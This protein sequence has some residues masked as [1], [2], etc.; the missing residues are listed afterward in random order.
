MIED[1]LP[2]PVLPII[3]AVL[4]SCPALVA[5]ERYM[6]PMR[7]GVKLA[8]NVYLP[9][10]EGP[11]PVILS[12]T[13]YGRFKIDE[14]TRNGYAVVTQDW[15]G[16]GGSEGEKLPFEAEGWGGLRDGYDTM[17]WIAA[18][19][20]CNGKVGTW[21][22]SA[23]GIAQNLMAGSYP[24][25]LVCQHI[26]AAAWD[27]Y[28]DM[29]FQGGVL[30]K[31]LV[32]GWWLTHGEQDH[33]QELLSHPDYDDRWRLLNCSRRVENM[34]YPAMHI[35][36]WYD[37]F[38][39]GTIDAFVERQNLGAESSQGNQEMIIGPWWHGGFDSL[40]QG[41]LNY[42]DNAKYP[43]LWPDTVD[44]YDRW[45]KGE[46]PGPK[47]KPIRYYV[48]GNVDDPGAPGNEWRTASS[49]P[50]PHDEVNLY[51]PSEG[52]ARVP[53]EDLSSS[54]IYDPENP[55]PT[56]GVANLILDAGPMDQSPLEG[57]EDV[58]VFSTAPLL[59][60]VEITGRVRFQLHGSSSCPDTDF[61]VKLTDV[62]PDGRSMLITDGAIRGVHRYSLSESSP[63][64]PGTVYEF[65]IDLWS[66]SIIIDRGHRIR[67]DL[68][69]SNSPRFQPNPNTGTL[70]GERRVA[71][72]T[73]FMGVSNPS[74]LIIPVAG[75]DSDG[76][77]VY[78]YL[79]PLPNQAGAVPSEN[80]L[81]DRL[82]RAGENLGL[83][84]N[85]RLRD[86]LNHTLGQAEAGLDRGNIYR[87]GQLI[88]VVETA[89]GYDPVDPSEDG[90]SI[91]ETALS[92]AEGF[93]DRSDFSGM[94]ECIGA[95]RTL[96]RV[97]EELEG[98][99]AG[100]V[101]GEVLLEALQGFGAG[102]C[103]GA[104]RAADWMDMPRVQ[105]LAAA[106]Q[107]GRRAGVPQTDLA[108][109]EDIF[110]S[111]LERHL[112]WR[113]QS[114]EVAMEQVE[115]RLQALGIEVGE[116]RTVFTLLGVAFVLVSIAYRS[117]YE[118]DR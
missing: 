33:L 112:E 27:L 59:V 51:I 34:S 118:R 72:N 69:S 70:A 106:I 50:P 113:T 117:G 65:P 47:E 31:F 30:R 15:R 73:V 3:A 64:D 25:S 56:L 44:F 88:E 85:D 89:S 13:P 18:Q 9:N 49:W 28:P 5:G 41:E 20:W 99:D 66:T 7:D 92:L 102:G 19:G 77:G 40:T 52:L 96:V 108:V 76:D 67:V 26:L 54:Y 105:S 29:F 21:G 24:P 16:Y 90:R 97:Q 61:M 57:R 32:E 84:D 46:D 45:M 91:F 114:S 62:Y 74:R 12:R 78:D 103:S 63:M 35:G 79:D 86:L 38:L 53:G 14:F 11:W 6:V 94:L 23:L 111:S 60:P 116:T 68:S 71:N 104:A 58:L 109:I 80:Q 36:G 98:T 82:R 110:L 95:G 8:T 1:N 83:V 2:H 55:V 17:E 37:I 101:L 100:E 107:S 39:Q 75:P 87:G 43:G 48:M 115:N 22:G 93:A 10:G 42:P 4:I 81:R